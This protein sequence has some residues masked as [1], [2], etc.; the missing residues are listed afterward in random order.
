MYSTTSFIAPFVAFIGMMAL[1]STFGWNPQWEYPVQVLVTA[2]IILTLSRRAFSWRALRPLASIGVGVAVFVIWIGPDALW[3]SYRHFWLFQNSITGSAT[4][5]L[6]SG[7]QSD[8][9]F[10]AFR[11]IGTALIV[12]II[13]ELFW[14]GWLMRYLVNPEFQKVP[15]GT[16]TAS[17]FWLTAALF[18]TEHGSYWEVGLI[19]GAIYNWWLMR[20]E[21]LMDCMLAHAVTNACLAIYVL[22]FGH[23]EYWL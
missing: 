5:T 22:G 7:A 1:R 23:W 13:E 16:Y 14:R 8:F 19:A 10:L 20:T 11:L 18:A 15:L 12:P 2:A 17:A 4:S 9:T 6:P 3:P 21:N